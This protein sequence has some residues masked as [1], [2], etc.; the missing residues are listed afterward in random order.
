MKNDSRMAFCVPRAGNAYDRDA[1]SV[2]S[3]LLC[4]EATRAK[5][6]FK[7]ECDINTIVRRFGITGELPVGVRMPSYGDFTGLSDMHTALNAIAQAREAFDAMP[8]DVRRRFDNDPAKFVDFCDDE[9][10]RPEAV[11]LGLVAAQVVD[12]AAGAAPGAA[13]VAAAPSA[14]VVAPKGA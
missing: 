1:D 2:A 7:E 10:N 5:Q 13:A 6:S 8:A 9:Q 3:G 14:A 11:R 4:V 12:L